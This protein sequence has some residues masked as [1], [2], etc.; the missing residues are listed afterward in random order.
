MVVGA[1]LAVMGVAPVN[2]AVLVK[3]A[4]SLTTAEVIS[5]AESLSVVVAVVTS[6][7][8]SGVVVSGVVVIA[9]L[10]VAVLLVNSVVWAGAVVAVATAATC[11]A[12]TVGSSW[13]DGA[14]LS[15]L[16]RAKTVIRAM[17][18]TPTAASAN[19]VRVDRLG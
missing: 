18:M 4:L 8:V 19:P 17:A 2:M 9:L 15:R 7:V 3:G 16:R 10:V 1:I 14:P 5:A 12:V 13:V 6:V 11:S